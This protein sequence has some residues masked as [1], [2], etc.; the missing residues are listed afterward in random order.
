MQSRQAERG[1]TAERR[2]DPLQNIPYKTVSGYFDV[3]TGN[4][5]FAFNL[6]GTSTQVAST[7][8]DAHTGHKYTVALPGTATPD[9]ADR[10]S[11][12]QGPA[13]HFGAFVR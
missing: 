11:V 4:N 12:R 5:L 7:T 9:V 6:A 2:T 13:R 3:S 1:C 8:V 10:R